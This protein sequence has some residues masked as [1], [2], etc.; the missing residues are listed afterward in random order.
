MMKLAKHPD[1]LRSEL[2]A[3]EAKPIIE[4]QTVFSLLKANFGVDFTHYKEAT[5]NRLITRR[6]VKL[7]ITAIL[8]AEKDLLLQTG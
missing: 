8:K 7:R 4:K 5:I 6:M 3:T 1:I 2:K